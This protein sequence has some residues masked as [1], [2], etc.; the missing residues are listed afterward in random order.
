LLLRPTTPDDARRA[1]EI[2]SSWK[3]SRMLA[4]VGY[5]PSQQEIEDWF[6]SHRDEWLA[7]SAFRF[8]V[9]LDGRF[10]GLADVDEIA[11]GEGS[12][13]YWLDEDVWG[14]GFAREA[15]GA[16]VQ[17][18]FGEVGLVRLRAGHADDNP[19]SG[20]VL[21]ALGFQYTGDRELWYRSRGEMVTHRRHLLERG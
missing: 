12:L 17:Y 4:Q 21:M 11:E 3:V 9:T 10:L 19:A 18:V 20:K 15:A 7:G 14:Q 8:A 13:G 16:V 1:F 6:R 5:P 2:Q